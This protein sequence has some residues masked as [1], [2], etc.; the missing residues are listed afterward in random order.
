[1]TTYRDLGPTMPLTA[2]ADPQNKIAAGN[3]TL[4]ADPQALNCRVA[5]AEVYQITVD[6]P[7]GFGFDLYRNSRKWNTVAQGWQN[8]YDPQQPL[9]IRPGDSLFF[10]WR[11]ASSLL[12]APTAVIWLKYDI[13]LPE[14]KAYTGEAG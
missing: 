3:W 8:N 6:G 7:V 12:P 13:D 1:V 4:T 14:N 2:V 9:W 11:A 10:Y 5:L